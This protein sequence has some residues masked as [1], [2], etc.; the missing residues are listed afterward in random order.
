MSCIFNHHEKEIFEKR[1]LCFVRVDWMIQ[2]EP[3]SE[4]NYKN[5]D[6]LQKA[7]D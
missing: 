5:L 3:S 4:G 7:P 2:T 6:R 1:D